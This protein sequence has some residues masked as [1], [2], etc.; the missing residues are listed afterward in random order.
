ML[1]NFFLGNHPGIESL[2]GIR[3]VTI[4]IKAGLEELGHKVILSTD[5]LVKNGINLVY[6][7]FSD[8]FINCIVSNP[9]LSYGIIC[10][11]LFDGTLI[12][13][14]QGNSWLERAI[15]LR[16]AAHQADFL[17]VFSP[18]SMSAY[19][20]LVRHHGRCFPITLGYTGSLNE[21]APA[22]RMAERDL[23]FMGA[24]TPYR[25]KVIKRLAQAGFSIAMTTGRQPVF[26]R[27]AIL[28]QGRVH[29]ALRM[30]EDWKYPS[31]SRIV[32]LLTNGR[33]IVAEACLQCERFED[34]TLR[35]ESD[36]LVE[37]CDLA[38]HDTTVR[39]SLEQ[40]IARFRDEIRMR[41]IMERLID[42]TFGGGVG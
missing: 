40:R 24:L 13:D 28:E 16:R 10:S 36:Q 30:N 17:W 15:N 25:V 26:L 38:L 37:A 20:T 4:F 27:N 23:V 41:D 22:E 32:Y 8:E 34:Y 11:E 9:T 7:N 42:Q 18:E 2:E 19:A 29:L 39:Q 6:E 1:F 14:F 12:N 31:H 5:H 21:L 35:V 33:R 3:D